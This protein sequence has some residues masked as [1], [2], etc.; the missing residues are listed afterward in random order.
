VLLPLASI[1]AVLA[2]ATVA[3]APLTLDALRLWLVV[4]VL[5][6]LLVTLP[7]YDA[8][9]PTGGTRRSS[10]Q[11]WPARALLVWTAVFAALLFQIAQFECDGCGPYAFSMGVISLA[12]WFGG[13]VAFGVWR[14]SAFARTP[15]DQ[16]G[17]PLDVRFGPGRWIVTDAEGLPGVT[18]GRTI[19]SPSHAAS[20][21]SSTR[22]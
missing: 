21:S 19:G 16:D 20:G 18:A 6:L 4:A 11:R 17:L 7:L 12:V 3:A 10:R 15:D 9:A 13:A 5:G 2:L 8:V 22:A 1:G 14:L